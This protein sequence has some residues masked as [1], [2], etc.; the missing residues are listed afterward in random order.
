MLLNDHKVARY[1]RL[2]AGSGSLRPG[3]FCG[4]PNYLLTHTL[5]SATPN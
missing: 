5:A 3:A 4:S 2:A 1:G